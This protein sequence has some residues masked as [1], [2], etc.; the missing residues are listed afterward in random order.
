MKQCMYCYSDHLP[1]A[2]IVQ[3]KKIHIVLVH[4]N[5]D[6]TY[7][8]FQINSFYSIQLDY[9]H[10]F[11]YNHSS[12]LMFY[13]M[14]RGQ[15]YDICPKVFDKFNVLLLCSKP[16]CF[17]WVGFIYILAISHFYLKMASGE[18]NRQSYECSPLL[19]IFFCVK[20]AERC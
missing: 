9:N 2:Q 5:Y 17:T 11:D 4:I 18:T 10:D 8:L 19:V 7:F 13:S 3:F 16:D 6:K 12:S 20:N 15:R 14:Q 1:T